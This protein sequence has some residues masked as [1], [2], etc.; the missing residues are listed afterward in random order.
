MINQA[1]DR[2]RKKYIDLQFKAHMYSIELQIAKQIYHKKH[3]RH[4]KTYKFY[5][6]KNMLLIQDMLII[7]SQAKIPNTQYRYKNTLEI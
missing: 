7:L 6:K 3:Q 5:T 2:P 1:L 4:F